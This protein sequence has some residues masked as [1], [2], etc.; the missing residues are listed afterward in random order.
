MCKDLG[1]PGEPLAQSSPGCINHGALSYGLGSKPGLCWAQPVPSAHT[2]THG[3]HLWSHSCTS[4]AAA[5][6][7]S[8]L[9]HLPP[10]PHALQPPPQPLHSEQSADLEGGVNVGTLDESSLWGQTYEVHV[11]TLTEPWTPGVPTFPS[12]PHGE[13][14]GRPV[15]V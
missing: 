15:L 3:L 11:H 8:I 9:Y 14:T 7:L 1:G 2:D 4:L 10:I 5:G 6:H 12:H 13:H